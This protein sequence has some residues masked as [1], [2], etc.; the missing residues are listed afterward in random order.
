MRASWASMRVLDG[1]GRLVSLKRTFSSS[2]HH[3]QEF[4]KCTPRVGRPLG[5]AAVR[6]NDPGITNQHKKLD[7]DVQVEKMFVS[8]PPPVLVPIPRTSPRAAG[9]FAFGRLLV[10]QLF[11]YYMYSQNNKSAA[12]TEVV[13]IPTLLCL[14]TVSYCAIVVLSFHTKAGR[15]S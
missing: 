15:S 3:Q 9:P 4:P 8:L 10:C 6:F 11:S 13:V 7:F 1:I 12:I 5:P 2:D 14:E